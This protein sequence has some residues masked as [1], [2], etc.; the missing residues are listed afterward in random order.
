MARCAIENG[1]DFLKLKKYIAYGTTAVL[2]FLVVIFAL[3]AFKQKEKSDIYTFFSM[4]EGYIALQGRIEEDM[5][6]SITK[7]LSAE[8]Q[9]AYVSEMI[10]PK[11]EE[12]AVMREKLALL[13]LG[14]RSKE[15]CDY[16]V[17]YVAL[18]NKK[19]KL[20]LASLEEESDQYNE[21]IGRLNKELTDL[22]YSFRKN[23]EVAD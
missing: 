15:V 13:N 19:I 12:I 16:L 14:G 23:C 6:S 1:V 8:E 5:S 10:M 11:V 4:E 7:N 3:S 17:K 22:I 2:S 21:E 18:Y 9:V 20:F